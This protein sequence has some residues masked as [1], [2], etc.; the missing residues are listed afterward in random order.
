MF[1]SGTTKSLVDSEHSRRNEEAWNF[2]LWYLQW[3]SEQNV[4]RRR[5]LSCFFFYTE[6]SN[7]VQVSLFLENFF[8]NWEVA[9]DVIKAIWIIILLNRYVRLLLILFVCRKR[10]ISSIQLLRH[11]CVLNVNLE[12]LSLSRREKPL[13]LPLM[14]HGSGSGYVEAETYRNAEARSFKKLGSGYVLET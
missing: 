12:L 8:F 10:W 2:G 6:T 11:Q 4:V 7:D 1:L 9:I 3:S 5:R 14:L 13:T